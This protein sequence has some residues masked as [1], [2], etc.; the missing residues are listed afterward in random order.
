MRATF[1]ARRGEPIWHH[2][3]D[4]THSRVAGKTGVIAGF[5]GGPCPSDCDSFRRLTGKPH[6]KVTGSRDRPCIV[7]RRYAFLFR[8][9]QALIDLTD[10]LDPLMPFRMLQVEYVV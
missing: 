8:L 9:V 2:T 1:T 5:P 10:R 7:H 6:R 3:A 4:A